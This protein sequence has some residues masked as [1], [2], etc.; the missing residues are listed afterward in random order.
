MNYDIKNLADKFVEWI[1]EQFEVSE[2]DKVEV[3]KKK[4]AIKD[5]LDRIFRYT[6]SLQQDPDSLEILKYIIKLIDTNSWQRPFSRDNEQKFELEFESLTQKFHTYQEFRRNPQAREEL[7]E[8]VHSHN[9]YKKR[10]D[11]KTKVR[12]ILDDFPSLKHFVDNLIELANKNKRDI[13]GPKGR[14]VFL[15]DF[16]Y[17]KRTPIDIHERRFLLRTGIFH[18]CSNYLKFA[19][20][21]ED[22]IPFQYALTRFCAQF[23]DRAPKLTAFF[24]SRG[25]ESFELKE[26]PGIIDLFIWYFCAEE[27]KNNRR[28]YEICSVKPNCKGCPL[29]GSCLFSVLNTEL[30]L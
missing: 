28:T 27:M 13:L 15:R 19:D 14:D 10:F 25:I 11:V 26:S 22:Q 17:W 30:N 16:G 7:L 5:D 1:E 21:L 24:R 4:L 23:L 9:H 20:P 8:F 29:N 18:A 3:K 12:K 6:K 2:N